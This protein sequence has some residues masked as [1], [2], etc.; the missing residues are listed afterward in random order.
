MSA[1]L[2]AGVSHTG[3]FASGHVKDVLC[4]LWWFDSTAVKRFK[5]C[6]TSK[7]PPRGCDSFLRMIKI[8]RRT[9]AAWRVRRENDLPMQGLRIQARRLSQ[10]V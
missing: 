7:R 2:E 8:R 3:G 6:K 4:C 5:R 1:A 10:C 9:A